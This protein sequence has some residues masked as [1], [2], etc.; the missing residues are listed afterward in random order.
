MLP[1]PTRVLMAAAPAYAVVGVAWYALV[2]LGRERAL[3]AIAGATTVLALALSFIL[4]PDGDE[5]GASVAFACSL[6]AM[7]AAM[8][9]VVVRARLA[10]GS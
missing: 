9:A 3:L 1:G 7:A 8:L 4:V 6:T 2:A 5:I 10:D